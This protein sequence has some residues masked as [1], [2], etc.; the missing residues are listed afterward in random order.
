MFKGSQPI[1]PM[2]TCMKSS[3]AALVLAV[4]L[5]SG[6]PAQM[7]IEEY[8]PKS[9]LKVPAHDVPRAKYPFI[10][11]HS[12][13][14]DMSPARLRALLT[15]MDKLNLAVM[16]NL[17]GRSGERLKTYADNIKATAPNRFVVFANVNFQGVDQPGWG[18][19]AAAQLE[20]DY[21]NGA[22]GLKI[23]KD[24]GLTVK[25]S[26]GERIHTDDPRIAP[27][28]EKA[29][30]LGIPV[31][32]HT[33]EPA[34]F[35]DPMDRFNERW[36]EL[37]LHPDRARPASVYPSWEVIMTE[38]WN[39]FRKHRNTKFIN[40]HLGWL[41]SDLDR[42]GK[43]LDEMPNVYTEMAAVAY[44]LG[45]QPRHARTFLIKYQDRVMMGKDTWA[46][47]EFPT[48][49]RIFETAD[50]YFPWYRNYHAF[51]GMYGL[52]LPDEVLKKIYYRNALKVI[53]GID[54]SLFP[55]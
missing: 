51:W 41:G 9:R 22:R 1:L 6:I 26:K 31:L 45:R 53:P 16:V 4:T 44:D 8:A 13:Q 42:L 43:L 50:E 30:E 33:G 46:P 19:R 27:V 20:Q 54:K 12:H 40:A 32:I 21:R 15:D 23:F 25:D 24:L 17:S 34:A 5:P 39:V 7:T 35:F 14:N 29:G 37:K 3:I 18:A 10:D 55:N 48:Y 38:Q 47:D 52:D 2:D 11:V 49:F 36:L 28:W